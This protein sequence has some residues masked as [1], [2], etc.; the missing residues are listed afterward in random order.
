M[1]TGIGP[2]SSGSQA[3]VASVVTSTLLAGLGFSGGVIS[4][5]PSSIWPS[6]SPTH[7]PSSPHPNAE[8]T[9]PTKETPAS[10]VTTTNDKGETGGEDAESSKDHREDREREGEDKEEEDEEEKDDKERKRSGSLKKAGWKD[11]GPVVK[12]PSGKTPDSTA[13][14]KQHTE[15]DPD[16]PPPGR[17]GWLEVYSYSLLDSNTTTT[18]DTANGMAAF[19]LPKASTVTLRPGITGDKKLWPFSIHTGEST[20]LFT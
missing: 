1:A 12:Q 9:K 20:N 11:D 10:A 15:S 4:S 5:F 2:S 7:N 3:T 16:N 6:R 18:T 14:V 13:K 8:P 19:P 17:V